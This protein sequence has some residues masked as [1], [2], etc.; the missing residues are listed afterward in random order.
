MG[1]SM[2]QLK[3]K[4]DIFP[5]RTFGVNNKKRCSTLLIMKGNAHEISPHT[6]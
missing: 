4:I 3:L 2:T 6:C 1:N 5:K